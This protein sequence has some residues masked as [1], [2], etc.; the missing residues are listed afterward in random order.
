MGV[1]SILFHSTSR[2][3]MELIDEIC[4]YIL[5]IL[6]LLLFNKTSNNYILQSI[7][8]AIIVLILIS[9]IVYLI[10]KNYFL[11]VH[12]FT[13]TIITVLVNIIYSNY[14]DNT[15]RSYITRAIFYIS[16]SKICWQLEQN[17]CSEYKWLYIFH[18]FWHILSAIA[19]HYLIHILYNI[20][21]NYNK[22]S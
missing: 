15:M 5:I 4:M 13:L 20:E 9:I 17:I 10:I 12:S 14:V 22:R 2:Y 16:I 19:V 3:S 7:N 11:F 8:T 21:L 6:V 18:S 1:G